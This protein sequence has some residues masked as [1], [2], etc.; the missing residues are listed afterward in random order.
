MWFSI[1]C[2]QY[3]MP[4]GYP[5]ASMGSLTQQKGNVVAV[6]FNKVKNMWWEQVLHL[7]YSLLAM[8]SH[9]PVGLNKSVCTKLTMFLNIGMCGAFSELRTR[10]EISYIRVGLK[11]VER[12]LKR[13]GMNK[14]VEKGNLTKFQFCK[15][16]SFPSVDLEGMCVILLLSNEKC[17]RYPANHVKIV[18]TQVSTQ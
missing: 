17:G 11:E 1:A 9:F 15:F 14:E 12:S 4:S 7:L 3:A 6:S 5:I 13:Y 18:K 16:T 8:I 10:L 2:H